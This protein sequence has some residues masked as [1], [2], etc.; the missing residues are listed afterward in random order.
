MAK[1]T[2]KRKRAAASVMELIA[3]APPTK[4]VPE[5][6]SRVE[7]RY[8]PCGMCLKSKQQIA[9]TDCDLEWEIPGHPDHIF[10]DVCVDCLPD[11]TLREECSVLVYAAMRERFKGSTASVEIKQ[12]VHVAWR[13]F[14]VEFDHKS[15]VKMARKLKVKHPWLKGKRA[16]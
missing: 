14:W 13:V 16:K 3:E 7:R 9:L 2:K 12:A 1:K 8:S 4:K 11:Y 10:R 15:L 6:A 5:K